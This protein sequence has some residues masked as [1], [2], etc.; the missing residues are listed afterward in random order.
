VQEEDNNG[1]EGVK[2]GILLHLHKGSVSLSLGGGA[3]FIYMAST[4]AVSE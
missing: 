2:C 3:I 1:E 4:I